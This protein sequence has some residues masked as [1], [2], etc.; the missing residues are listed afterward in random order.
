MLNKLPTKIT[1]FLCLTMG[2]G[3][4][5]AYAKTIDVTLLYRN[6][7]TTVG[8]AYC[9]L[10]MEHGKRTPVIVREGYVCEWEMIVRIPY[11]AA[12]DDS[13]GAR[14][15]GTSEESVSLYAEI[16]HPGAEA[17]LLTPPILV[18]Q[19]GM[20]EGV[21]LDLSRGLFEGGRPVKLPVSRRL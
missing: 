1:V 8:P 9:K 7:Y 20:E 6:P 21:T 18:G 5:Y 12:Y 2:V 13:I 14:Y 19:V 15:G 10:I 4:S 16:I 11:V 17:S 3:V